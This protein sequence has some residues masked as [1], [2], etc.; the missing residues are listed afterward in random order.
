MTTRIT[1]GA[2]FALLL[3]VAP[4][5]SQ[6]LLG[7]VLGIVTDSSGAA[8]EGADVTVRSLATNLRVAT[9]SAGNGLYQ[10]PNLPI[11]TYT[12]TFE[13]TGFQS[14][15]HP[16]IIV[17]A[18][19]TITL[20]GSLHPGTVTT[21][22]EVTGTPLTNETD[23]SNGYVLDES[24]IR[25]VPL[26]T[27]SFTQLAL[28]SPGVSADFLAGT[29]SNTGLGNQPIWANGQRDSSNSFVVNGVNSDNLFS[30][31]SGSQVDSSRF[32]L[33]TGQGNTVAGE[34]RTNTSVYDAI[35]QS[36]PSPPQEALQEMRV[37][38]GMFDATQGAR[39]GA[40]IALITKSGSNAFH[41]E[42]YEYLQN[43]IFNAAP[44]FRN[45]N[46][47]IPNSQKVP[48][49]HFNRPGGTLGGPVIKNRLFFFASWQ[50]LR[51]SDNLSGTQTATVPQHLSSDRSA[52]A[53]AAVAQQDLGVTI[54]PSQINPAA[55]QIM[56]LKLNGAYII[57]SPTILDP[58]TA[59]QLG[60]NTTVIGS[61]S[62]SK[63]D[64]GTASIDYNLS[65]R[66]R[67][68]LKMI[69]QDSPNFNPYGGGAAINGFGKSL[70]AGA[71]LASIDYTRIVRP[72]LTWE[73]K[74]GFIRQRAYA[75]TA[76][77][78]TP[79]DAGINLFGI[80]TFPQINMGIVDTNLNKSLS[81]GPS[82]NFANVGT[83]QNKWDLTTNA[84][85]IA[86]R[87]TI[88]FGA[89]WNHTQLNIINGNTEAA[90]IG[91]TNFA[92]FLT[93]AVLPSSTFYN[94]AANRYYRADQIGAFVQDN[95]KMKSNFTI[96]LGLRYDYEGP[97][98]EK[99]G[100]LV[101]FD[102][103]LYKY[104]A[105]TDTI[106]NSGLVFAGN[107]PYATS[108]VSNSTLKGRQWGFGP[109]IGA[110]WSPKALSHLILRGGYGLYFDRGEYFTFFSPG[111]GRGFSGPFGV[112]MQLPFTVPIAPPP[113]ATLSNPFGA[114][115]PGS[116]GDPSILAKQLPN[117]AQTTS[118][119]GPYIFG[120]Y[121]AHNQLPYVQ[122]WSFDI[123][124]QPLN[125][126]IF[127][128]GYVGNHG[129]NQVLPIP[130]NQPGIATAQNPI[131]GQTSSYGFNIQANEPI[132]TFEG[133]NTDLRVP[134]IGYSS[135]SVLYQAIGV[136]NYNALQSSLKKS[137][138]HNLQATVSYTWSHA[139]DEQSNLGVFFNGN[140]PLEPHQSYGTATFDRTHVFNSTYYY[141]LP[142]TKTKGVLSTFTNGWALTGI[143]TLQSGQPYNLYDFSGAVGGLYNSTTINIADPTLGFA[144]G[145]TISQI[146]LQSTSSVQPLKPTIDTSKIYIPTVQ[147]GTFGVPACS[148][149]P[150][151]TYETVFSNTGRNIFRGPF[152]SR[153]DGALSKRTHITER[154][155]MDLRWDVFNIFNHPDF[156][157]P[158]TS[159]GLYSVTRSGN[160]IKAVTVRDPKTTT[161]GLI[162]QTLGSPRIMQL[163]LHLTF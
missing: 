37:N 49:L 31:K 93:G 107:S 3:A 20:N 47:S 96:N 27:G 39:S 55:L 78:F 12:V 72:N 4:I 92:T 148:A 46:T 100:T 35:G 19:R 126:W 110:V 112:T 127:T 42:V 149:S 157:V 90:S 91:F 14:E 52:T 101:N 40:H 103:D 160:V 69:Y 102:S 97:L 146:M 137:F 138:S 121:D 154:I 77:P 56:N 106:T 8:V 114:T 122:N 81:F 108:G 18:E 94:G 17:Q 58:V 1:L 7:T 43:N 105:A 60:Y 22:V 13:K 11:G 2:F 6:G 98:S 38:T 28:L 104:D 57:P 113:G 63:A 51:I 128:V 84:N 65:D 125:S 87:H 109:R 142:R 115:A 130:F 80:D 144:P 123:Q 139:L 73:S 134:F 83:F 54:A 117:L 23:V 147:P 79:A 64:I 61:P 44:F 89:S 118:G 34:V 53:L 136:S 75:Q 116:P 67:L 32:T 45:A 88:Y 74:A 119:T 120:G 143:V 163:S 76:Q 145:T 86:G 152:Q 36:I 24:T 62:T 150:C 59:K 141:E 21:T 140:N 82:G 33:N 68:S 131:H 124:Y 16:Q 66:D 5:R 161:L 50:S 158:V 85:W 48:P 41:G 25:N 9:K 30:G 135:N 95:Y 132:A 26:G 29:S 133:G 70:E 99:H 156:D 10:I 15:T 111:A 162:Q 153:W 159:T 155:S 129:S 71:V 151:D